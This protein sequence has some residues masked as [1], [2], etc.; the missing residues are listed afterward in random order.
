[1]GGLYNISALLV[2]FQGTPAV[3]SGTFR[4]EPPTGPYQMPKIFVTF[5]GTLPD[6]TEV[7]L[8]DVEV[9]PGV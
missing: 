7:H 6:G 2:N 3:Y 1:M 4:S 5:H 9:T 8:D